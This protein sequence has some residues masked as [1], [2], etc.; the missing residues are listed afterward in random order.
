MTTLE[1]LQINFSLFH[2]FFPTS[3]SLHPHATRKLSPQ[4]SMR[5]L[6]NYLRGL[7]FECFSPTFFRALTFIFDHSD[8]AFCFFC[9]LVPLLMLASDLSSGFC[10]Q[11]FAKQLAMI[12]T[13]MCV[14]FDGES[15]VQ[16]KAA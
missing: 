3:S 4:L 14:Q 7:M 9:L 10:R 12:F 16:V 5:N 6:N 8:S 1:F 11:F 2:P 13:T 15:S